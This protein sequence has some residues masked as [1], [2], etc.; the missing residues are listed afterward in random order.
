[1]SQYFHEPCERCSGNVKDKLNLSNCVRK[2]GLKGA[3]SI[4]DSTLASKTNLAS[5]KSLKALASFTIVDG[6]SY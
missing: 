3:T 1:M 2:V 5:L 4:D 6:H